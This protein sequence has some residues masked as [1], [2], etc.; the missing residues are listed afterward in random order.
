MKILNIKD[1]K[2]IE[3]MKVA[4]CGLNY[5]YWCT[6]FPIVKQMADFSILGK[7]K[8]LIVKGHRPQT[9]KNYEEY[10]KLALSDVSLRR[11]TLSDA[12]VLLKEYDALACWCAPLQCHCDVIINY[13]TEDK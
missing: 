2:T 9:I 7:P 13:I 8:N 6:I 10:L 11:V 3:G 5:K 4:Y 12:L 1:L